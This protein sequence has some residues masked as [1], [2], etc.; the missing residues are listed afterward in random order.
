M[1]G[2]EISIKMRLWAVEWSGKMLGGRPHD[3]HSLPMACRL[4]G[5]DIHGHLA[6]MSR[7]KFDGLATSTD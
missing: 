3:H 1:M 7:G 5:K 6:I 4:S 2:I